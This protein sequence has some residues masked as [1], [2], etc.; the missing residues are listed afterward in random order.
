MSLSLLSGFVVNANFFSYVKF[1]YL[2]PMLNGMDFCKVGH[3]LLQNLATGA[4]VF[5]MTH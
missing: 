2:I 1:K 4:F 3:L 5:I